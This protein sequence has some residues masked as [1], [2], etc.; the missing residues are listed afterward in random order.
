MNLLKTCTVTSNSPAKTES[1]AE[2]IGQALRGGEVVELISDLGGGKTTFVRGLTRGF[3]SSD[4]VSSPT[5][6]INQQYQSGNRTIH[7]FDFYRLADPGLM[8]HELRDVLADPSAVTVIEWSKVIKYAL[9]R[10]RLTVAI[11]YGSE[12]TR[13]LRLSCPKFL[14]YLLEGVC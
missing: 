2:K 14:T 8:E 5:F 10:K 6:T 12:N 4:H 3:G 1:I 13:T 9:P 11:E 7:H